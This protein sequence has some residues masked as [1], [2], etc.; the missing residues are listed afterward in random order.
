MKNWLLKYGFVQSTMLA[1]NTIKY[2]E[3]NGFKEP[4]TYKQNSESLKA[5]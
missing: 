3:L 5:N 1:A 2:L 4:E